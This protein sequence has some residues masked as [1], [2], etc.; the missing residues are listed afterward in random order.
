MALQKQRRL[1]WDQHVVLADGFVER[2]LEEIYVRAYR[3]G[4]RGRRGGPFVPENEPKSRHQSFILNSRVVE[5]V[6][7]NT[8]NWGYEDGRLGKTPKPFLDEQ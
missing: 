6:A 5:D 8:Y 1:T 2:Y 7:R 3:D 4:I